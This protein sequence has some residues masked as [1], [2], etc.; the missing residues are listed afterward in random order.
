MTRRR[1]LVFAGTVLA[2]CVT[3]GVQLVTPAPSLPANS[4]AW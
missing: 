2:L 3:T 4:G 1:F